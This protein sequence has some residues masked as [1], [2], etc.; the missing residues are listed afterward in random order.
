[1][2]IQYVAKYFATYCILLPLQSRALFAKSKTIEAIRFDYSMKNISLPEPTNYK[3]QLTEKTESIGRRM[4]WRAFFTLN[5][6]ANAT[7][8]ETSSFKSRKATPPVR[9][10]NNLERRL[11]DLVENVEFCTV[12][13]PFPNQ[14]SRCIKHK[15]G[16]VLA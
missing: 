1:M 5:P 2:Y 8:K 3:R 12:H 7:G 15:V 13:C 16:P 9:K 14:L 4:R 10:M 6:D 11:L